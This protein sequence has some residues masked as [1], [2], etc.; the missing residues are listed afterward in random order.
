VRGVEV[1]L[2]EGTFVGAVA[3]GVGDRALVGGH[4]FS[5]GVAELIKAES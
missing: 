5:A 3:E 1:F 4:L 2:F